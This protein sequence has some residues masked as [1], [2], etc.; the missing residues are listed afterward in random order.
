MRARLSGHRRPPVT[1][2]VA[3]VTQP[4]FDDRRLSF[5]AHAASYADHRPGYPVEAVHWVLGA[6]E[7]PVVE[8]ADV[9][10]GTGALTRT[11]VGLGLEVSAYEPDPGMLA[12]LRTRVPAAAAE[13]AP[14]EQLPRA[15]ASL[16]AILVG[17]AWHWFDHAAASD[18]FARVIRP[19]GVLG[20]VWNLRDLSQPWTQALADLIGGED[21]M[22][23][24]ARDPEAKYVQ[25]GA[26]WGPVERAEIPHAVEQDEDSLVAL[27]STYSYVRL[28]P[29]AEQ[30]YAEIRELV[31]TSPDLRGRDTFPL[32][33]VTTT[34]R[35]VRA[36]R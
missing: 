18:E 9:G 4:P 13:V 29:D 35:A 31:R 6:A 16:D 19:G 10:A 30:V 28:R 36:G 12:E 17:Q 23:S 11:L 1:D 27:V 8:V 26:G 7:R 2:N 34:Y 21:T 32:P 5:G 14:A 24:P 25:L 3:A 15:D 33:Y 22:Q 20:L